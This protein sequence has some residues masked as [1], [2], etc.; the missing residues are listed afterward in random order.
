MRLWRD[1]RG[2]AA[3][4]WMAALLL[5]L[6]VGAVYDVYAAYHYRT[7]GYQVTGEAARYAVLQGS[8]LNYAS[9]DAGLAPDVANKAAQDFL[10]SRLAE[11]G[12][13]DYAF[14]TQVV[15]AALG[16]SVPGFPPVAYASLDGQ[17]MT[18]SGPGVGVYLE[19]SFPTAWLSLVGRD[20]YRLHVFSAAELAAVEQVP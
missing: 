10:R 15:V 1:R 16:G 13:T 5:I 18:V 8:G 19:F 12:I 14:Q 2:N 11:Q 6:C 7:W 20:R 3:L 9:G 17:P 4:G